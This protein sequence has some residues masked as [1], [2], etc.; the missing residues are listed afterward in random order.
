MFDLLC[1]AVTLLIKTT[2]LLT[3][4]TYITGGKLLGLSVKLSR[5]DDASLLSLLVMVINL[6]DV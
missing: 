5:I 3:Y 4:L 2:Y 6:R 1:A